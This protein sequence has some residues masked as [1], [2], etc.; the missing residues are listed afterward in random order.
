MT[1]FWIRNLTSRN[2][3][4]TGAWLVSRPGAGALG[5]P[6]AGGAGTLEPGAPGVA[7]GAPVDPGRALSIRFRRDIAYTPSRPEGPTTD[8]VHRH[9][10]NDF[11]WVDLPAVVGGARSRPLADD[12]PGEA[13]DVLGDLGLPVGQE[14]RYATVECVDHAPAVADD[15]LVHLAAD[16]VLDVRDADA[17]RRVGPVED[18]PDLAALVAELVG[19]LEEE[20]HVLDARD[21]EAEHREDDVGRVEDRQRRVVEEGRAVDDDE[22]V[23][24]AQRLEDLLDAGRRDQL[25]H[26]RARAAR[27]G[28]G[29]RRSG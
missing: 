18:E 11:F 26:L 29:C 13:Q 16:R 1:R 4:R 24:A 2:D 19:D 20:A 9:A 22:V 23:V 3:S 14:E 8:R 6:P 27:A 21:L 5:G 28:R 12:R 25:G 17:E 10:N 7:L 15:R